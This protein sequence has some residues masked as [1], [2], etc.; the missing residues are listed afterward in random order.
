M[1]TIINFVL[2]CSD[3]SKLI[4][5]TKRLKFTSQSLHKHLVNSSTLLKKIID[6]NKEVKKKIDGSKKRE[7]IENMLV[8]SFRSKSN[9]KKMT[10]LQKFI[11]EEEAE[12]DLD[13]IEVTGGRTTPE[14]EEAK[15]MI[16]ILE[17][18]LEK[19]KMEF[20]A[21]FRELEVKL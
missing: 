14:V 13:E 5:S 12:D 21:E 8:E 18:Q 15:E 4:S 10:K 9:E 11:T 17:E 20:E 3:S 6:E 2:K 19:E 7:V 1:K 16:K